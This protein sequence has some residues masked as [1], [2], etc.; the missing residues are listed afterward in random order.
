MTVIN[1]ALGKVY[2][3]IPRQILE[4]GLTRKASISLDAAL[5]DLVIRPTVLTDVNLVSG[6]MTLVPL[7]SAERVAIDPFSA[8]YNIGQHILAGR[9]IN[10]AYSVGMGFSPV[11]NFLP[12]QTAGMTPGPTCSNNT[13]ANAQRSL[14]RSV[15][16]GF[17]PINADVR[18]LGSDSIYVNFYG[19]ILYINALRC[20]VS[21]DDNL[22]SIHPKSHIAF[23][24]LVV[25]ATKAYLYNN[26]KV[27]LDQGYYFNG[28][29]IGSV[30]EII[31]SY[32][33]AYSEYMIYLKTKWARVAFINDKINHSRLIRM[34]IPGNF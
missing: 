5:M 16:D 23:A 6:E 14:D 15:N 27:V 18:L 10:A 12:L 19:P 21:Y 26:L 1:F 8:V 31:E 28:V 30:K 29:E 32:S 13:L 34:Q 4:I 22:S 24:E 25:L 11:G 3:A 17:S 2:S 7:I 33:E 20:T 9:K